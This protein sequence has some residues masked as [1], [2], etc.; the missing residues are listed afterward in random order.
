MSD[1]TVDKL[2]DGVIANAMQI[3]NDTTS[4][5]IENLEKVKHYTTTEAKSQL[6][7]LI[8]EIIGDSGVLTNKEYGIGDLIKIG[9]QEELRASQR[10]KLKEMMGD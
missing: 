7:T 4:L 9:H 5:N 10:A 8:E 6:Y 2:L 1:T 3:I